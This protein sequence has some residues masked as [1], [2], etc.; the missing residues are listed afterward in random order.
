MEKFPLIM[1]NT[2]AARLDM[3]TA[4]ALQYDILAYLDK[5]GSMPNTILEI[6][7]KV[8]QNTQGSEENVDHQFRYRA[9]R[10][11]PLMLD[12]CFNP[13]RVLIKEVLKT[14]FKPPGSSFL[15]ENYFNLCWPKKWKEIKTR[16][17]NAN[18]QLSMLM[19]VTGM[20]SINN[21][22]GISQTQINESN[23][24]GI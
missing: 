8:L 4:N 23:D 13:D 22:F 15:N 2:E 9:G 20:S 3:D 19:D 6:E 5:N 1:Q 16:R 7:R 24:S 21:S 12:D 10:L 11:L 18:P 14:C 17:L